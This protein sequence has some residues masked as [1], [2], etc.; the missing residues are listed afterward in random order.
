MPASDKPRPQLPES[1]VQIWEPVDMPT[2]EDPPIA[3]VQSQV[4]EFVGQSFELAPDVDLNERQPATKILLELARLDTIVSL[5]E[6]V[7]PEVRTV[8]PR[9]SNGHKAA[10]AWLDRFG[11]L[12]TEQL[13]RAVWPWAS[14]EW[15]QKILGEL[16]RA[17]LVERRRAQLKAGAGR[18]RGGRAPWMWSLTAAGLRQGKAWRIPDDELTWSALCQPQIPEERRWR[19]SEARS[20]S[21]L[22]HD[23]HTAEWAMALCR[24]AADW[25][26]FGVLDVLTPRYREGQLSPPRKQAIFGARQYGVSL[27]AVDLDRGWI[28]DG[29]STGPFVGTIKPDL[30]LRLWIETGKRTDCEFDLLVELDRT[31]RR[32]KNTRKLI[33]YDEFLT[34]WALLH[35]RVKKQG[36][37]VVIFV[38]PDETCRRGLMEAADELVVGRIGQVGMPAHHW[39]YPGRE[40]LLFTTEQLIHHG[41]LLAWRLPVLPPDVR[42]ADGNR[43][44]D[45]QLV[46]ILPV[47]IMPLDPPSPWGA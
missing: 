36:R 47:D 29:I 16:L 6:P 7:P 3:A 43:T 14:L 33:A 22:G 1:Y 46:T 2:P 20:W 28:F 37:P 41:S 40:H 38:C 21:G 45:E 19:R 34:G 5:G 44:F 30:T 15:M 23:L 13:R 31:R 8:L 18:R 10:L 4:L 25:R 39:R 35:P 32:A 27:D 42:E 26:T 17:G 9:E 11:C 24:L 12:T